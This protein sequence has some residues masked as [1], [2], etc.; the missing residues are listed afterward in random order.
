[1]IIGS[2]HSS[3]GAGSY[4]ASANELRGLDPVSGAPSSCPDTI[5]FSFR[6]GTTEGQTL[7]GARMLSDPAV[8]F[9]LGTRCTAWSQ[10][11][12]CKHGNTREYGRHSLN[13]TA[14]RADAF[15]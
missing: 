11:V 2:S 12:W 1:M 15:C 10:A 7:H 5:L 13:V 3:H 8:A 4:G 9:F 14:L 6:D